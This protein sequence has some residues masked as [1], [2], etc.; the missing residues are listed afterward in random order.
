[1]TVI[2]SDTFA[3]VTKIPSKEIF[4]CNIE[5]IHQVLNPSHANRKCRIFMTDK[6]LEVR[7]VC[8]CTGEA[9]PQGQRPVLGPSIQEEP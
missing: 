5:C 3:V 4:L 8:I 2:C 7:A 9:S 6:E 1:M